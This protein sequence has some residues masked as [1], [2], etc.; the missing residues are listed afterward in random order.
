M[1]EFLS[2]NATHPEMTDNWQ[3]SAGPNP[4]TARLH[5]YTACTATEIPA[6]RRQQLAI[7]SSMVSWLNVATYN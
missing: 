6:Q 2:A 5:Q 1:T 3:L 4:E 7:D